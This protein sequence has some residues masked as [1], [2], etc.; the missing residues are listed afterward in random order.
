MRGLAERDGL[1]S[2]IHVPYCAGAW[3]AYF[4]RERFT[5]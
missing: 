2:L 5:P 3:G 1:S 4:W